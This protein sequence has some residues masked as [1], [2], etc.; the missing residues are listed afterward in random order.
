MHVN[1][2]IFSKL[3]GFGKQDINQITVFLLDFVHKSQGTSYL[4]G[5]EGKKKEGIEQRLFCRKNSTGSQLL[6]I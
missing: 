1:V 3:E 6:P 2:K 4:G 5:K